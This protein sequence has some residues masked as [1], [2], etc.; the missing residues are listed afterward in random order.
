MSMLI[1]CIII[2]EAKSEG[3]T[4]NTIICSTNS[5]CSRNKSQPPSILLRGSFNP[6]RAKGAELYAREIQ[7]RNS[8]GQVQ[9]AFH[10]LRTQHKREQDNVKCRC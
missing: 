9:S 1:V 10:K 4:Q 8:K 7:E 5:T 6:E 3:L 2:T